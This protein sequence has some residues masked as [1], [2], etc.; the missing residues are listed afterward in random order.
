MTTSHPVAS[1]NDTEI[2]PAQVR[3]IK[4]GQGGKWEKECVEKGIVRY[5]FDSANADRFPLPQGS[6]KS[7]Q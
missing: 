1:S 4:L 5:G 6:L 2:N 7:G 3:Y